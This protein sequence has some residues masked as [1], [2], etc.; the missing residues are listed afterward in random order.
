MKNKESWKQIKN[1]PN[2]EASNKGRI[3][4]RDTKNVFTITNIKGRFYRTSIRKYGKSKEIT[5]HREVAKAFLDIDYDNYRIK[6]KNGNKLD[7]RPENLEIVPLKKSNIVHR[8]FAAR[9]VLLVI[10]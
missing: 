10:F 6:H 1:F 3:R 2:Y 9:N 7:N 4:N 5:I 8:D